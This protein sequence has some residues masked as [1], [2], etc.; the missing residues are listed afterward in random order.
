MLGDMNQ[1]DK[2]GVVCLNGIN[3][4]LSSEWLPTAEK[5]SQKGHRVIIID[6]HS[7][8]KT[9][10]KLLWGG[11]S[12]AD[13]QRIVRDN[14]IFDEFK[15]KKVV[16]LGKSWGGRQA[17]LFAGRYPQLVSKLGL[18]CPASSR[19]SI[20]NGMKESKVPT[21][22]GWA[23]DDYV[24][25]YSNTFVW[26]SALSDQLTLVTAEKGGHFILPEFVEPLI[27]FIDSD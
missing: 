20:V 19:A 16:L 2:I 1:V 24:K 25:W 4:K 26:K 14:I 10:P 3:P 17:S 6:F 7:N 27:R 18:I 11:I 21:F 23:K 5:L 12:D 15:A 8:E 13:V 9:A 22:M